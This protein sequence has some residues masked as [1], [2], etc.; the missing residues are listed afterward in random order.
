MPFASKKLMDERGKIHHLGLGVGEVAPSVILTAEMEQV[1]VIA[2][3]LEGAVET[4]RN[5]EYLTYTGTA[6]GVPV[7]VMS[8]GNGCMPMA[9]AAE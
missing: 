8:T 6:G 3:L 2:G 9:S 1:P 4:G 7:S 5:R